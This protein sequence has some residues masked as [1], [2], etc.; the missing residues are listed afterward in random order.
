M[1]LQVE[2]NLNPKA[3]KGLKTIPDDVLYSIARQTLDMSVNSIP[4]S[5]GLSTSGNLRRTSLD[6]GVRG[7]NKN[8]YIGSYTSYAAYVWNMNDSTT[9]WTT[10][11]THSQWYM[12]TLKK[13]GQTIID[14]ALTKSWKETM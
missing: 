5:V 11:N 10:P 2:F 1:E 9:N 7:G 6:G 3:E 12:R 13:N 14:N 4:K 8:Y